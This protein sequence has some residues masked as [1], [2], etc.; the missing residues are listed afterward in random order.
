MSADQKQPVKELHEIIPAN[1]VHTSIIRLKDDD[2]K[3]G[4]FI[5]ML[6]SFGFIPR[7]ISVS[8]VQGQ[9]NRFIVSAEKT[10]QILAY[11]KHQLEK[12]EFVTLD[13]KKDEKNDKTKN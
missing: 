8:K 4:V 9:N 11:E 12:A 6:K 5:D 2:H 13:T 10:P 1:W 3:R 7:F